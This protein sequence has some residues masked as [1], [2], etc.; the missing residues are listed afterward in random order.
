MAPGASRALD[1]TATVVQYPEPDEPTD[2]SLTPGMPPIRHR[3]RHS[4]PAL[5]AAL[6]AVTA[7][8]VAGGGQ[9]PAPPTAALPR[10]PGTAVVTVTPEP[11]WF[12]EPS[13]AVDPRDP[14]HLVAAY[15]DN[16]HA[17]WSR[18][19]G[20]TWTVVDAAPPDFRVSGD[21]SVAFDDAGRAYI[22][23]I[24]FDR[25]GTTDYWAS[26][27]SRNGIFVRRSPD[28][29]A[30]WD[31]R[32]ADVKAFRDTRP[33]IPW[34]DKPYIVADAGARSPHRGALY[35][36]WT[37]FRLDSSVILF[38]RSTDGAT[39][40]SVPIRISTHAGLP[41]DDNGNVEGFTAAVGPRGTVYAAWADGNSIAFTTSRDGGTSF[42]PSRSVIHTA[43]PYF[44]V[45]GVARANGFPEIGLDPRTGRLFLTWSDYRNGDVDVFAATSADRGRTWSPPVRVND[46]TLHDGDDQF[47]Q[48]LAVDPATGAANVLFYDRRGDP[49]DRATR[50]TLARST[51]GGRA[52]ANFAW[53]TTPFD[54]GNAFIGD[55]TG[56]AA[57]N[58]RVYGIWTEETPLPADP[59]ARRRPHSV[60]RIGVADFTPR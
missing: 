5:A 12:T 33:G 45:A 15:Q 57:M 9:Q 7:C 13:I 30:T 24:A 48:W 51:D 46:D 55:Y 1:G 32:D 14:R 21:V 28:G 49:D 27:S 38:S 26:H 35:V 50:V 37:E 41:R 4:R 43:P 36:G 19:G 23:Y 6:A 2:P 22:C 3:S 17:A 16:A 40:W 18:D 59:A 44:K 58:G 52:W 42:A 25:L 47:F 8:A 56:L 10:A 54:G 20:R 60:V 34:E 53:T 11:G 29:G 31:A 39:S